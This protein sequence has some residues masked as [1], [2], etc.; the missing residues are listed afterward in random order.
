MK[1]KIWDTTVFLFALIALV[2]PF[3]RLILSLTGTVIPFD[4]I[5][6]VIAAPYLLLFVLAE[7]PVAVKGMMGRKVEPLNMTYYLLAVVMFMFLVPYQQV[8]TNLTGLSEFVIVRENL[9]VTNTMTFVMVWVATSFILCGFGQNSRGDLTWPLGVVVTLYELA[10]KV[11]ASF[12]KEEVVVAKVVARETYIPQR[13]ITTD[14]PVTNTIKSDFATAKEANR[15]SGL[16]QRPQVD[17]GNNTLAN[18]QEAQK[19]AEQ[20]KP[21]TP[22]FVVKAQSQEA[23][24]A[25]S[26]FATPVA[27]SR[28]TEK[29][30]AVKAVEVPK[31][32]K[33]SA[34]VVVAPVNSVAKELTVTDTKSTEAEAE[35][36]VA[37]LGIRGE[38][39]EKT[40]RSSMNA[41]LFSGFGYNLLGKENKKPG[42]LLTMDKLEALKLLRKMLELPENKEKKEEFEKLM[43]A[44]N[45][46]L[47]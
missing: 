39:K 17:M 12:K 18:L 16:G 43:N 35:Y 26:K 6:A 22:A 34:E 7:V 2:F 13:Q 38:G 11:A 19:R 3:I 10:V 24:K 8:G 23:P 25:P 5:M 47:A 41:F 37:Q 31:D 36:F 46:V 45:A 15:Q 4:G 20:N 40:G 21:Q 30:E 9:L 32:T 28:P 29:S 14:K 33:N 1:R 44:R 27:A 42:D